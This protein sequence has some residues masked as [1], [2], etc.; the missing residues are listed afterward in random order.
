MRGDTLSEI[1]QRYNVSLRALRSLN[2]IR[3]DRIRIGQVL[4]IPPADG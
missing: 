2:G 4:R 3:N 1:A